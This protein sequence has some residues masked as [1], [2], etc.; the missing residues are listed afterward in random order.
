MEGTTK[1]SY[2]KCGIQCFW[3]VTH[4]RDESDYLCLY[5]T[6]LKSVSAKSLNFIEMQYQIA[7]T[8]CH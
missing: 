4:K 2:G 1:L 6:F 7:A 3:N 8:I 5:L